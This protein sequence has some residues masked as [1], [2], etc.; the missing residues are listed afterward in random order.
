MPFAQLVKK[1]LVFVPGSTLTAFIAPWTAYTGV[2]IPLSGVTAGT[3][4]S[5]SALTIAL[6]GQN[7]QDQ[8]IEWESISA[9]VQT[10]LTTNLIT[11]AIVWQVSNDN[12]NWVTMNQL[13]SAAYAAFAPAGTASLI[14]TTFVQYLQGY[15]PGYPYLR[16]AVLSGGA[17][18]AAGDNVKISYNARKRQT[19][20]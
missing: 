14:T 15:N 17:T 10:G 2:L 9:N 13:N 1:S 7:G 18:G 19:A 4:T 6:G 3:T 16:A 5:A 8:N 12:T 20:A 11:A